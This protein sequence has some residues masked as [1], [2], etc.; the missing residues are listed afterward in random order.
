M[1]HHSFTKSLIFFYLLLCSPFRYFCIDF[2]YLQSAS[3]NQFETLTIFQIDSVLNLHS[4]ALFS[5]RWFPIFSIYF[6]ITSSLYSTNRASSCWLSF[7]V[8]RPFY[9]FPVFC[10]LFPT[11]YSFSKEYCNDDS[12]W[13]PYHPQLPLS[14]FAIS[15]SRLQHSLHRFSSGIT[16]PHISHFSD[17]TNDGTKQRNDRSLL[18]TLTVYELPPTYRSQGFLAHSF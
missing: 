11:L 2:L 6:S 13:Q 10:F 17:I 16:C 7:T 1:F 14:I 12:L 4:S 3:V 8:A 15:I 5:P 18:H 9:A